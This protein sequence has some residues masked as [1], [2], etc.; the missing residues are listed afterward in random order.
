MISR[1]I[2]ITGLIA[3]LSL[4]YFGGQLFAQNL[5]FNPLEEACQNTGTSSVSSSDVCAEAAAQ[6]DTNPITGPGGTIATIARIIAILVGVAAVI[7]LI[8]S[9]FV[10]VTAGGSPVGQ[11]TGDTSR[12]GKAK[13]TFAYAIVGLAVA[14]LGWAIISFVTSRLL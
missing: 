1:L 13:S 10:F 4:F 9:G 7:M 5:P 12:I 8:Y 3:S 11:R 6:G 2:L 14:A